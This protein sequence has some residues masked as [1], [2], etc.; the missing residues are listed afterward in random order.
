MSGP[1]RSQ[2]RSGSS[3]TGIPSFTRALSPSM[4]GL[5]FGEQMG[6]NANEE[7]FAISLARCTSLNDVQATVPTSYRVVTDPALA[8]VYHDVERRVDIEAQHERLRQHKA[9]GS[10]PSW[11]K[12]LAKPPALQFT[13]PFLDTLGGDSEFSALAKTTMETAVRSFLDAA[14]AEKKKELD[15]YVARTEPLQGIANLLRVVDGFWAAKLEPRHQVLKIVAGANAP[16]ANDLVGPNAQELHG[17][18][19]DPAM[20]KQH[21]NIRRS[22]GRLHAAVVSLVLNRALIQQARNKSK[23]ELKQAADVEMAVDDESS[24]AATKRLEQQVQDLTKT[25][26]ALAKGETKARGTP[27]TAQAHKRKV[28]ASAPGKAGPSKRPNTKPGHMTSYVVPRPQ[29]HAQAQARV[30]RVKKSKDPKGKGKA[31]A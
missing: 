15:F 13:K 9:S 1:A 24:T 8:S 14:I 20:Q 26:N 28:S 10:L 27:S 19:T 5:V 16:S 22:V 30:D 25:V 3:S 21:E 7:R 6:F 17:L 31:K 4:A 29:A 23:E 11:L 18:V 12:G 2:P